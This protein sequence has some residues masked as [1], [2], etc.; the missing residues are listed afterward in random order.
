MASIS[1]SEATDK[2]AKEAREFASAVLT[3]TAIGRSLQDALHSLA[4]EDIDRS[5]AENDSDDSATHEQPPVHEVR[6]KPLVTMTETCQESILHSFRTGV[7]QTN[8]Q[9]AARTRRGR[10]RWAHTASNG[11]APTTHATGL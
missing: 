9:N 11:Q 7:A 1:F 2:E 5:E 3:G 8:N 10:A 4:Q 6:T